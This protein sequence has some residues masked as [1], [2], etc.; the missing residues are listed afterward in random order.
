M[1]SAR[2]LAALAVCALALAACGSASGPSSS[3]SPGTQA[4]DYLHCLRA[5]G[6]NFPEPRPVGAV[7]NPL[8]PA[9]RAAAKA[10]AKLKPVGLQSGLP[11]APTPGE[12]RAALAFA[13]CMRGHGL[14]QFPDPLTTYGPDAGLSVGRGEFFPLNSPTELQSPAFRRAADA[15]GLRL[16]TG[17]PS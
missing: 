16:T 4:L 17:P 10:C 2:L 6:V 7:P 8:S 14:S 11:P 12:L 3:G 1:P 13:R 15:C 9:F 5:N